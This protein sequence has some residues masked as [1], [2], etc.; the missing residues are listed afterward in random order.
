MH[1]FTYSL[2]YSSK[3]I[4]II[5][6]TLIVGTILSQPLWVKL[7]KKYSKLKALTTGI[8]TT[9]LGVFFVIIIYI[10]RIDLYPNSFYFM[11]GAV[12]ISGIGSGALYS[13]PTAIYGDELIRI[14][15]DNVATYTG[16]LTFSSNIAN[17]VVQLIIGVLLDVIKF[18]NKV[19]VQTLSVQ[20]GLALIL[21][22]GVQV[23]LIF[24]LMAFLRK[25]E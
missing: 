9:V 11:L 7:S 21:F 23:S 8:I 24:S 20:T 6:L 17:A 19:S 3:Q 14:D 2:F 15:R 1:F 18:D 10:F 5:L 4:T 16:A 25:K 12:F 13:L 22:I